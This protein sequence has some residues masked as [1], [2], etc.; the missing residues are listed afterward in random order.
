VGP[1]SLEMPSRSREDGIAFKIVVE[2]LEAFV[3]QLRAAGARFRGT[4]ARGR[5]G[6]QILL[7]DP[8]G[9]MIEI[10]EPP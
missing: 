9:N 8:S 4:M 1:A 2:D 7:E 5:G 6:N 10:F 3:E